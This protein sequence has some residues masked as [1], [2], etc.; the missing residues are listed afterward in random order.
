S[1]QPSA[2]AKPPRD[3][4]THRR[5]SPT[6]RA[7][8]V[9]VERRGASEHGYNTD[10]REGRPDLEFRE[11]TS[12]RNAHTSEDDVAVRSQSFPIDRWLGFSV[13]RDLS[14]QRSGL[15]ADAADLRLQ[16]GDPRSP[17]H[18]RSPS[19]AFARRNRA[20]AGIRRSPRRRSAGRRAPGR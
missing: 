13:A 20:R 15:P 16:S 10:D 7:K 2:Y 9:Y 11:K 3:T 6:L 4:R 14:S 5:I 19:A 8:T 12:E 18:A 1:L 17:G